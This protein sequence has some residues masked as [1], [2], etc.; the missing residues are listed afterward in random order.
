M[1]LRNRTTTTPLL[2]TYE[3]EAMYLHIDPQGCALFCQD[4][5]EPL[6]Q[7]KEPLLLAQGIMTD[8][9]TVHLVILKANGELCYS[10]ISRS[11]T[12]QTSLLA[13]L[14]V[15]S[16]KY[17]RVFL[18]PQGKMIHIFYGYAHQSI[19]GLWRIEH[20]F[21]DGT[22]WHS[23]RM[24]EVVHPR[25]PLYHVNLD[26]QGNIHILTMTFQGSHSLF[27]T[28][29][30]NGTFHIWGTPTETLKI[31]GEVIDMAAFMTSDNVQYLFW[32][33]KTI[34]G[35]FELR[36]AQQTGAHVLTSLWHPSPAP[37]KTLSSPSKG[38]GVIE[39]NGVIWLLAHTN[40]EILMQ[41]D[42]IGWKFIASHTPFHRSIQW[43]HKG[44]RNNH[45][46][47]WLEDQTE[48]RAP[49]YY[50]ELGFNLKKQNTPP[51]LTF[52]NTLAHFNSPAATPPPPPVPAFY[53]DLVSQNSYPLPSISLPQNEVRTPNPSETIQPQVS[54]R[55]D[56]RTLETFGS[57]FPVEILNQTEAPQIRE[58]SE[59][60][61]EP[62]V[63]EIPQAAE[64]LEAS[65]IT[66]VSAVSEVLEV[67]EVAEL[68][69]AS[70]VAGLPE[71]SQVAELPDATN[72]DSEE[73]TMT[74]S[75][76]E[77]SRLERL[78]TTV[79]HLEEENINMSLILHNMLSKF[80]QILEVLVANS[81]QTKQETALSEESQT[82]F[83]ELE[84]VKEAMA[85]LEKET[86]SLSQVMRI[87]LNK[88][89]ENDSSLEN[90]EVRISQLQEEQKDTKNKGGFW[91]KWIT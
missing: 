63:Q 39:L 80:D 81:F 44:S 91:N 72:N 2:L 7:S 68:P 29:R 90:I 26:S 46:T 75:L 85:N 4:S 49:A 31:S 27:F 77:N 14:D 87:M 65:E 56:P 66:D 10:L 86:Q 60:I 52:P 67:S 69:E 59:T 40:E 38:I 18:F 50:R 17:R 78:I 41:N 51:Y 19:P 6:Y 30:F 34:K 76:V 64:V 82:P 54:L 3:N 13:K 89:E 36:S 42:G 15:R 12:P 79:A 74:Q 70:E 73:N 22:S 9:E 48:R 43:V 24:G 71:T 53:P 11:G 61:E 57:P 32:V 83:D 35:Q 20:R 84:P 28:N 5:P 88:Q 45:Q 58:V 55:P 21:W 23:V 8:H 16:T 1:A 33:T 25:E 37:I 47:Y 62:Q